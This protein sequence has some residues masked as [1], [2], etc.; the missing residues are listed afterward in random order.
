MEAFHAA[1]S[2]LPDLSPDCWH[3]LAAAAKK[4]PQQR[5]SLGLLLVEPTFTLVRHQ[6]QKTLRS[7]SL[8]T[9]ICSS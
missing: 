4:P 7:G 6:A 2:S 5:G 8:R 1:S 9:K 3:Y